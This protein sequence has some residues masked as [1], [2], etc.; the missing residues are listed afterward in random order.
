[1]AY[2]H[3]FAHEALQSRLVLSLPLAV[4]TLVLGINQ[5]HG[6]WA[7][8]FQHAV[9]PRQPHLVQLSHPQILARHCMSLV[10]LVHGLPMRVILKPN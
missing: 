7:A 9:Q 2:Q 1:M 10:H 5:C 8:K 4:C 6:L 3:V